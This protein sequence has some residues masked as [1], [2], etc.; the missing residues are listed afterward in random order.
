MVG[1]QSLFTDAESIERLWE[2]SAPVLKH[3]PPLE[4]YAKR[5]WGPSSIAKVAAPHR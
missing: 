1:D 4:A 2:V 3:P 5:S